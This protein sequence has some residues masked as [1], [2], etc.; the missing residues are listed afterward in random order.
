[1]SNFDADNP[2]WVT[3][4]FAMH[5]IDDAWLAQFAGTSWLS[6]VIA[7]GTQG[8]HSHSGM[9]R[10]DKETGDIDVLELREFYGGRARPLAAHF[11]V[12]GRIDVFSPCRDGIYKDHF[13]PRGA[14]LAMHK[15]TAKNYGYWSVLPMFQ[16]RMPVVWRR[17]VVS[18][19]DELLDDQNAEVW[20]PF[21][22]HAVSLATQ[23][24]GGV[25]VVPRCPH[26]AVSPN[27]LTRSM[28][29]EYEF[30]LCTPQVVRTHRMEIE[31]TRVM[32][33]VNETNYARAHKSPG[34]T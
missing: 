17:Y 6:R 25:D 20:Q 18:T 13:R 32:L 30:S 23:S 24:G 5:Y 14:V 33:M 10:R 2:F 28:F 1:M 19:S 27:D 29:F 3:P 7:L 34:W 22:S 11:D 21:C 4:D 31:A 16:R 12:P 9:F 8:V 26:Y 15:L